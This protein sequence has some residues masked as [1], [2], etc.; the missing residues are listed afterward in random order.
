MAKTLKKFI[1]DVIESPDPE[2]WRGKRFDDFMI[3]LII[4]N[5]VA[6]VLETV[7]SIRAVFGTF[8]MYF[9]YFSV[10]L[11]SVEYGLRIWTADENEDERFHPPVRGRIRFAMTPLALIDIIAILPFYLSFIL[12][13][14]LRFM[15]VFRLLRLL[16][17]TRYSAALQMLGAAVYGQR[18]ALGAALVIIA[19]CFRFCPRIQQSDNRVQFVQ[20]A[21]EIS[22]AAACGIHHF[23]IFN[24]CE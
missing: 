12:A 10:A 19:W 15:R 2:D 21:H 1:F 23:H 16:K 17:L 18:R 5:V 3:V 4:T 8:F 6:V 14:D 9:E 24:F 20:H 22:A 11:F 7:E 13:V